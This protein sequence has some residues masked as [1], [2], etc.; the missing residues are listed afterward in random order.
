MNLLVRRCLAGTSLII[1][2]LGLAVLPA[3]AESRTALVIGNSAYSFGYLA[4]PVNDAA[5]VAAALRDDGF[6]VILKTDADQATMKAALTEFGNALKSRGGVGLFFFAGHGVQVNGE[7]FLIAI[8]DG[9]DNA[10]DLKRQSVS[11]TDIVNAIAATDDRL[12]IIILDACRDNPLSGVTHGLSR[13]DSNASLFVSYS[14]SPGAV[15]SDGADRNSPYTKQLKAAIEAPALTLEDVFKRV[16]KGVYQGT[17]GQQTPWISSTF[18][19][20]FVFRAPALAAP[21]PRAGQSLAKLESGRTNDA[22]R[23]LW[24]GARPRLGGVYR[25][26]GINPDGT[27]YSGIAAIADNGDEFHFTWWSGPRVYTG[28]GEF[29]GRMLVVNW[30]QVRPVIFTLAAADRL[31]GEWADGTATDN[32]ALFSRVATM[33]RT[34]GGH[35]LV[36]GL[37]PNGSRYSGTLD[38]RANGDRYDF[39]WVTGASHFQGSGTLAGNILAVNWGSSTTPIIYAVSDD[40]SLHGL[41]ADGHGEEVATPAH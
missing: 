38:V 2:A 9:I 25:V 27:H 34:P 15:A 14:T 33:P 1:A 39:D 29:A 4:N 26:D 19:G 21:G 18:F 5:D 23:A 17:N 35:Y 20:E 40:G 7:N 8:G 31:E 32:L 22:A 16:L 24:T 41:W 36:S 3:A 11:A 12:N 28:T 10:D 13:L 30:G 37:N 6:E